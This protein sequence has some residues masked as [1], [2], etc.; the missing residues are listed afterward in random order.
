MPELPDVTVYRER[1]QAILAGQ[2]LASVR[3]RSPF[4]LRSVAPPIDALVGRTLQHVERLG[5]RLVFDFGDAHFLVLHLRIAGRLQWHPRSKKLGG[6]IDLAAFDFPVGTL[7]ADRGLSQLL[8]RD[9]PKTLDE[10]EE[11]RRAP[12]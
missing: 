11:R 7:L 10:L 4:L 8:K 3:I 12:G 6:R 9:W 1:L 2:S 5:K